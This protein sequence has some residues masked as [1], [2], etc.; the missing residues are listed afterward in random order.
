MSML[1]LHEHAG[2]LAAAGYLFPGGGLFLSQ[3]FFPTAITHQV[4][5]AASYASIST[6][7]GP[8]TTEMAN[9]VVTLASGIATTTCHARNT[10]VT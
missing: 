6:V 8:T 9:A 2:S 10:A 7:P 3:V 5:G 1:L 4:P